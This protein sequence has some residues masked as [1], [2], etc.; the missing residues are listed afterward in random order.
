MGSYFGSG[1]HWWAWGLGVALAIIFW[2]LVIWAIVALIGWAH[3][4]RSGPGGPGGPGGRG[5]SPG[6]WAPDDPHRT[7][8]PVAGLDRQYPAGEIDAEEY[9][10]WL[11]TVRSRTF[12]GSGIR[13]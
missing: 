11:D 2:A 1:I 4:G 9:R 8:D 10:R 7:A 12:A 5:P 3:H 13:S 6:P